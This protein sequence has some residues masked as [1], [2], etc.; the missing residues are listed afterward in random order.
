MNF[1][2]RWVLRFFLKVVKHC[3]LRDSTRKFRTVCPKTEKD[4]YPNVSRE[5]R[6][7]VSREVVKLGIISKEMV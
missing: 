6:G 3:F 1:L 7:T 4:L 5:E 2:Y